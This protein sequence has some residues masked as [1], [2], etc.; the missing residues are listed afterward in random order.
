MLYH[1]SSIKQRDVQWIRC[2]LCN[3]D[4]FIGQ[5]KMPGLQLCP[6]QISFDW[7]LNLYIQCS[8]FYILGANGVYQWHIIIVFFYYHW[9]Q[10]VCWFDH[11][12]YYWVERFVV[13]FK[14]LLQSTYLCP[15]VPRDQV[16]RRGC[17]CLPENIDF[18][19]TK[20][21]TN[22]QVCIGSRY[23]KVMFWS[24][25]ICIISVSVEHGC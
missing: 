18:C 20:T 12:N 16:C 9:L 14:L 3:D 8:V 24:F 7:S 10:H 4:A 23:D 17:H 13:M 5:K 6:G 2:R 15:A 19:P 25:V 11:N 1:S 22:E 21:G